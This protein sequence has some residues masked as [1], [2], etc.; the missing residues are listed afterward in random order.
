MSLKKFYQGKKVFVTGH[1][2]FKGAWL[3]L[4]LKKFGAEVTGYS[5]EPYD[6]RGNL[7][8]L[9]TVEEGLHSIYGDIRDAEKLTTKF[10][11]AEPNIVFHLA[12]QPFVRASYADPVYNYDTNLMG[13]VNIMEAVRKTDSVRT[14]INITT[15]KCYENKEWCWPYR[16][17]DHLGGHDPYSASKACSEIITASY[18]KSFLSQ[19]VGV[20]TAR[21]GNVIGGGDFGEDRIIPDIVESLQEN[22]PVILRSPEAI[23]PWQHVFDVLNGYMILGKKCYS[24]PEKYSV[25]YNFSPPSAI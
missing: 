13:T 20:A 21:A 24:E 2:G 19:S 12:A 17:N 5:L 9:A 4:I 3:C 11:A 16:E 7:F 22:Q 25:A 18:R 14:I 15:D 6:R 23:R 1:T 8:N 10:M